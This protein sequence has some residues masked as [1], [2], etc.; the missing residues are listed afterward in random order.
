MWGNRRRMWYPVVVSA[1]TGL[2][3][4]G[5]RAALATMFDLPPPAPAVTPAP[6]S[7]RSGPLWAPHV[8][9]DTIR[10]SIES[11]RDPDTVRA[12]LPRDHA[13]N[14]DWVV[15]RRQGIIDPLPGIPGQPAPT[16]PLAGFQ[17]AF[18]FNYQGPDTTFD[19]LFPHSVHTEWLQCQQCHP[20]IFPYRNTL[21][22]MGDLFQGR[23]CAECHGKVAFPVITGCE[24][25][26]QRL[27]MPPD[28]AQPVFLGTLQLHRVAT[29]SGNAAGVDVS[30]LS[31]ATFPHW[32]HR[33][34]FQ[35]KTCHMDLFAPRNGANAVT[36]ADINA[37]R[38]CGACHNGTVAFRAGF[39][40]C[41][42]C[43]VPGAAGP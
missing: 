40:Q 29:D 2:A 30:A 42:R 28:R 3:A 36:M 37:G 13:G 10:P 43:H 34:R 25:C 19:A 31:R 39:G 16:D 7:P 17:F 12:R 23:F 21:V 11:V 9:L 22:T 27:Q 15:A 6:T 8:S 32:A 5:C 33:M 18:D 14:I 20:R 26:H 38:S 1:A 4:L 24:R 41:E 35:C